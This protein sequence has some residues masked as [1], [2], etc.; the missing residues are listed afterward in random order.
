M[1]QIFTPD[2]AK[3]V[4]DQMPAQ[5]RQGQTMHFAN[6]D[7]GRYW[8]IYPITKGGHLIGMTEVSFGNCVGRTPDLPVN[9]IYV[10]P[11]GNTW[12][13][14]RMHDGTYSRQH[15]F[16]ADHLES[17]YPDQSWRDIMPQITKDVNTADGIGLIVSMKADYDEL[18]AVNIEEKPALG[19]GATALFRHLVDLITS[20]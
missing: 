15:D 11:I 12:H 8:S 18:V 14:S 20:L 13:W 3:S 17:Q 2:A 10:D 16:E 5:I 19:H 6:K 1:A 7:F 4:I 9:L